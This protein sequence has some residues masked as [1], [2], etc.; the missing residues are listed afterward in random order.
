MRV[1]AMYKDN[2]Y[3]KN[4]RQC[5]RDVI[6]DKCGRFFTPLLRLF[7]VVWNMG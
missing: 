5:R 6:N 7:R 3:V 4:E 2:Y 1:A